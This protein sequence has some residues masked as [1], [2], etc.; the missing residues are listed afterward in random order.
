ML[1]D[2]PHRYGEGAAELRKDEPLQLLEQ[3]GALLRVVGHRLGVVQILDW[4]ADAVRDVDDLGRDERRLRVFVGEETEGAAVARGHIVRE[5]V[6]VGDGREGVLRDEGEIPDLGAWWGGEVGDIGGEVHR[7][8]LRRDAEALLDALGDEMDAA[9]I[10]K[11][12]EEGDEA[13]GEDRITAALLPQLAG[14]LRVVL[15]ELANLFLGE[16]RGEARADG[17]PADAIP[18]EDDVDVAIPVNGE[19][20]GFTQLRETG[21]LE[22]VERHDEVGVGGAADDVDTILALELG[23]LDGVDAADNAGEDVRVAGEEAGLGRR[24]IGDVRVFPCVDVGR[25]LGEAPAGRGVAGV[26]GVADVGVET[27]EPARLEHVGAAAR[28][29]GLGEVAGVRLDDLGGDDGE[30]GRAERGDGG[31]PGE[32]HLEGEGGVIGGI[33]PGHER[34]LERVDLGCEIGEGRG[35]TGKAVGDVLG[36]DRAAARS[37]G[38]EAE[39][40]LEIEHEREGVGLLPAGGC[41]PPG[42]VLN[43]GIAEEVVVGERRPGVAGDGDGGVVAGIGE[44]ALQT[45]RAAGPGTAGGLGGRCGGGFGGGFGGGG[46][47]GFGGGCLLRG[48]GGGLGGG[49]GGCGRGGRFG[50]VVVIVAA[51]NGHKAG[52]AGGGSG[53]AREDVPARDAPAPVLAPIALCHPVLPKR[54]D[55]RV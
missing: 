53:A 15:L 29:D 34:E 6:V 20:E 16:N 33:E 32:A 35:E 1:L 17:R 27:V 14:A 28:V 13:V 18:L 9:S 52:S 30:G 44:G 26:I 54:Q 49:F 23:G 45:H 19:R 47:G 46:R 38:V 37:L 11:G 5:G 10:R 36:R 4:L 41:V 50:L 25:V 3:G 7:L 22:G 12:G 43:E 2:S 21:P 51:A 24:R 40:G 55:R 39:V 48:F 31:D 42:L 8:Q